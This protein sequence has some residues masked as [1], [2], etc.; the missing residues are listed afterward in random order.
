M[1]IDQHDT[2]DMLAR[3]DPRGGACGLSD[4]PQVCAD[5]PRFLSQ[6]TV[7][8]WRQLPELASSRVRLRE[9]RLSD[10][11]S[12]TE[13]LGSPQVS[14]HLSCSPASMAETE[15]FI[16]WTRRA[17]LAGRYICFGVI[18]AG[19]DVAVGVFQLWPLEPS[20]HTAEW[21][22]AIGHRF[23]GSG[24]FMAGARLVTTFVFETLGVHRLEA[25]AASDND[26]GN[27]VLKKLG[28]FR[29]GVLRQCFQTN[30]AYRDH[31]MWSILAAD[32]RAA[33]TDIAGPVTGAV[34]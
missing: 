7:E 6:Q 18:P 11:P 5:S 31:V 17:R 30:G 27:A 33:H 32:W 22:F 26:R 21:G 24:L 28:A 23:W 1:L 25:R 14:Q 20:F 15:E 13:A 16:E 34:A 8:W 9:L 19:G 10:A 4:R 12:L 29:E 3:L 2:I